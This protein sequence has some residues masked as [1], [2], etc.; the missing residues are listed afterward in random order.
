VWS[1]WRVFNRGCANQRLNFCD[2]R[3][4]LEFLS[5]LPV[6]D[7]L[8]PSSRVY[9]GGGLPTDVQATAISRF[10]R[11]WV[12][13]LPLLLA[14]HSTNWAVHLTLAEVKRRSGGPADSGSRGRVDGA[15]AVLILSTSKPSGRAVGWH[16]DVLT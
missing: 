6:P 11:E 16:A 7:E 10:V 15:V 4:L 8:E 12:S 3:E 14:S 9:I 13:A 5:A 1:P 2:A